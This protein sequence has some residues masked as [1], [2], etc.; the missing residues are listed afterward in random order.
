M[1]SRKID[2]FLN[3]S[4]TA[5]NFLLLY[6]DLL[7]IYQTHTS[8]ATK[9]LKSEKFQYK[10]F[11]LNRYF[12]K[13]IKNESI[14]FSTSFSTSQKQLKGIFK[15]KRKKT[16]INEKSENRYFFKFLEN[17]SKFLLYLALLPIFYTHLLEK[18]ILK[19]RKNSNTKISH[20]PPSPQK[21]QQNRCF[22]DSRVIY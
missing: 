11:T 10:T 5:Q 4:K 8:F 3:C 17:Y 20:S 14:F 18:E 6:F 12:C 13:N 1:N 15:K 9:I 2:V 22:T 7:Q 19:F 21:N 16:K